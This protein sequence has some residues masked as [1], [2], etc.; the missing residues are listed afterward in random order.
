MK[1]KGDTMRK[2]L[3][4]SACL[5]A[6]FT[7]VGAQSD[8]TGEWRIDPPSGEGQYVIFDLAVDGARVTGTVGQRVLDVPVG[9][10]SL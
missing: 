3:A 5:V 9:A 7:T 8:V 1:E 2:G 10:V 4:M 6:W